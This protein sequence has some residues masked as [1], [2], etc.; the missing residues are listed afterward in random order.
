MRGL[1]SPETTELVRTAL[2]A[3]IGTPPATDHRS[4][5]QR[6]ADALGDLARFFLDAG[7][8]S[9]GGS[10]GGKVKPH[11]TVSVGWDGFT[12]Q[13]KQ[14][15][16]DPA[17]FTETGQPIPRTVFERIACDSEVTRIVFGPDSEPLDVGRTHRTVTP[18]QR[19]AVIARDR[20]CRGPDC[21]APPRLC[22]V[23]HLIWWTRGGMTSVENS[24][25]FCWRCHDRI[26]TEDITITHQAGTWTFTHPDGRT[27]IRGPDQLTA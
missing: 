10:G 18:G 16:V 23:H 2:R 21:H 7:T 15:G 19:K 22:E 4:T 24:G 8:C 12:Q 6:Y 17:T 14:A 3:I 1:L 25:L 27:T 11:L 20:T 9:A 13:A 26:H 5:P